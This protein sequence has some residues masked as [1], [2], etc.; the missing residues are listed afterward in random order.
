VAKKVS[1]RLVIDASVARSA[2]MS[3]DQT[4]TACR[5]FL[6]EVL[7][8]CHKVVLTHDIDREWQYAA[9]QIH[10]AADRKRSRFLVGWMFAMDRKG[11]LLRVHVSHDDRLRDKINRMGLPSSERHAVQEDLHLIE[12]ARVSDHCHIEG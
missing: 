4:S 3:D 5:E 6:H 8:V 10:S 1:R 12:A 7:T 2:T 9:L 11:K